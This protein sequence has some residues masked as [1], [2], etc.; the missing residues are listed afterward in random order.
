MLLLTMR[1]ILLQLI[2]VNLTQK[3]TNRFLV[4]QIPEAIRGKYSEGRRMGG[5]I[6]PAFLGRINGT[7]ICLTCD[8]ICHALRAWQ[9]GVYKDQVDLKP[10]AAG[11][12]PEPRPFSFPR[13][14]T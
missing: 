1:P 13:R 5:I 14:L 2:R 7:M 10:E 6:N 12:E 8:I 9:T 4:P 11:S 3:I